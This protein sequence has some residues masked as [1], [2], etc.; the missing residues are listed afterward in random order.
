MKRI[1]LSLLLAPALVMGQEPDGYYKNCEGAGGKD[2]LMRLYET[3]GPHTKVTY[4]GLWNVYKDSDVRPNGTVWDMYSTKEWRSWTKC[5]N[6]KNVGDCLNREHS[7]PKSWWGGGKANQYSDAF[8]LYPTDGKVNNQ[9]SN[10]PFGECAGGDYLPSNGSVRPLGRLGNSTFPGFSGEVFEPDDQYKGDFARSYF[11]M[12][13]AYNDKISGW[14]SGNGGQMLAG[15]N[16]PV[17]KSWAIDMLLKW[18]RQDPV[19]QKEIDR[20]NAVYKHQG[21]R[22]P[23]IDHPELAEYI[24][25][26]KKDAK[27]SLGATTEPELMLPADGSV[28]DIGLCAVG[29]SKSVEIKV[30]GVGLTEEIGRAHV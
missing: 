9:R 19:S 2:L 20:N 27:W 23:F 8:H 11:Y 1:L 5:G 29:L 12:A 10:Y 16:Y 28:A 6:Y 25:G 4:D 17:Y 15:N 3:V 26:S 30:K 22:N 13:A 21:N 7:F 14:T 18:H 24:W